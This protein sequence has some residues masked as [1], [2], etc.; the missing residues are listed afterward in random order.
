MFGQ[1]IVNPSR[2]ADGIADKINISTLYIAL[3]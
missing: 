2:P 1:D 3:L